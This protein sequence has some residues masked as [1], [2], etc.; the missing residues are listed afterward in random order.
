MFDDGEGVRRGEGAVRGTL[1]NV[2]GV[3]AVAVDVEVQRAASVVGNIHYRMV[4]GAAIRA[5]R[6]AGDGINRAE[7]ITRAGERLDVGTIAGGTTAACVFEYAA[8]GKRGRF[9]E[10]I[11]QLRALISVTVTAEDG[12]HSAGFQDRAEFRA[13]FDQL[14]FGV[15]IVAAFGIGRVVEHDND[16]GLGGGCEVESQ[17]CSHRAVF[18]DS[19][20]GRIIHSPAAGL[21]VEVDEVDVAVVKAVIVFGAAVHS[22]A[23]AQGGE[24]EHVEVGSGASGAVNIGIVVA[25]GGPQRHFAEGGRINVEEARFVFGVSAGIV[26]VVT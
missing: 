11:D 18:V 16:P 13:H 1:L 22:A 4:E 10:V 19:S 15:G 21:R 23:L 24:G 5:A 6:A 14:A 9:V 20:G 7:V 3:E 12:V 25:Q 2:G 17:P 8:P 26:G